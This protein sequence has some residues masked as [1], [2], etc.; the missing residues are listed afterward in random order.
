M[1]IEVKD[2]IPTYPGRVKMTPVAGQE[3]TF[4]MVRADA[5]IEAG[6]PINRALFESINTVIEATK[7]AIENKLFEYSQRVR[8]G[9]LAV[10]SVLGL[11]ENGVI[12]PYIKVDAVKSNAD[13]R[14]TVL[15]LDC[16]KYDTF[17][18][19]EDQ[20]NYFGGKIDVWL[21]GEFFNSLD[22]AT[23]GVLSEVTIFATGTDDTATQARRKIFIP[24]AGEYGFS[25]N[26]SVS[27]HG[28]VF[29]YF[30]GAQY[31]SVSKFN[32]TPVRHW[33]RSTVYNQDVGSVITP[34]GSLFEQVSTLAEQAGIR[35][36][37]LLPV[38]FEVTAS[39]SSTANVNAAA[40]VI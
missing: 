19:P 4:D 8:V 24:S 38:D 23:R 40:E 32:G 37:F 6:T 22:D 30:D 35:P 34:E 29:D 31:R 12:V 14:S 9:D 16:I 26:N 36:A 3:N 33:T 20:R 7:Q 25:Y 2:R 11:H 13:Q 15:R 39:V 18:R 17:M 27:P 10:G 28:T 1:M 21:N 5:P